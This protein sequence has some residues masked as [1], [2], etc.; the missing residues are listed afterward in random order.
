[1]RTAK[2]KLLA[3]AAV[4]LIGTGTLVAIA[5]EKK[6]ADPARPAGP[7]LAGV[8]DDPA[9]TAFPHIKPLDSDGVARFF[10]DRL[11]LVKASPDDPPATRLNK[12]KLRLSV[13]AF[14]Y[15]FQ[16]IASDRFDDRVLPGMARA[17]RDATDAA[18]ELWPAADDRRPWLQM[19]VGVQLEVERYIMARARAGTG[20]NLDAGPVL[21]RDVVTAQSAR[22]DAELA[23]LKLGPGK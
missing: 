22:L 5:Q 21:N 11:R 19:L 10:A 2:L 16:L 13:Q 14:H 7:A 8:P 18:A 1:M 4:G 3:A 17:V 6:P 9:P 12:A 15:N 20:P 23:L